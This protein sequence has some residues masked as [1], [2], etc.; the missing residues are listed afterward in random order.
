LFV[1]VVVP[2]PPPP[3]RLPHVR[4]EASRGV[5]VCPRLVVA[6]PFAPARAAQANSLFISSVSCP[7]LVCPRRPHFLRA[8]KNVLKNEYLFF[9]P[10]QRVCL[11]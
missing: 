8:Q 4:R 6:R 2:P 7:P 11:V 10:R 1:F 3:S 9:N 5:D